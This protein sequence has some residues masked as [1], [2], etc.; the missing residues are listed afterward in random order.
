MLVMFSVTAY[1]RYHQEPDGEPR[2]H[3]LPSRERLKSSYPG[4]SIYANDTIFNMPN[5]HIYV[6]VMDTI[7]GDYCTIDDDYVD[8]N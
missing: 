7:E 1:S 6:N 8:L 5:T 4:S 3:P 2:Y